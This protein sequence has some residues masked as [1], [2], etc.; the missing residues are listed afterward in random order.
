M[1]LWKPYVTG[2]LAGPEG[3]LPEECFFRLSLMN[4]DHDGLG[5]A[6]LV[7]LWFCRS[8]NLNAAVQE[9][10]ISDTPRLY[11]GD[12]TSAMNSAELNWL[13]AV[14]LSDSNF[15]CG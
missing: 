7:E 5:A 10:W 6:K 15:H 8:Q 2:K 11:N 3:I 4:I 12:G 13:S 14:R 1:H 9:Y